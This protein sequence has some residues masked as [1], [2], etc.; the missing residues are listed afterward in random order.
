MSRYDS[1][2]SM[3][4]YDS[5]EYNVTCGLINN[6]KLKGGK[7]SSSFLMLQG[8]FFGN[9]ARGILPFKLNHLPIIVRSNLLALPFHFIELKGTHSLASLAQIEDHLL[10]KDTILYTLHLMLGNKV[11]PSTSSYDFFCIRS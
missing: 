6:Y 4:R 1:Y 7:W 11:K 8:C 9:N 10:N 5:Y 3:S 2:E